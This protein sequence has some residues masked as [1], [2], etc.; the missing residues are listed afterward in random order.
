MA[1]ESLVMMIVNKSIMPV[2]RLQVVEVVAQDDD[3][4]EPPISIEPVAE[5]EEDHVS[6][7]EVEVEVVEV[8]A[9]D[10][11]TTEP[12]FQYCIAEIKQ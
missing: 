1:S 10:D 4:T 8:V 9:Q 5:K 2:P 11:N 6:D 7:S 3:N 12:P